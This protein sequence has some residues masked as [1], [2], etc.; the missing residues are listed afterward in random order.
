MSASARVAAVVTGALVTL[1]T[2]V[3]PGT[4]GADQAGFGPTPTPSAPHEVC[5]VAP[6]GHARCFAEIGTPSRGGFGVRG[7]AAHTAAASA[8]PIG[9]GPA[10]LR[11]AYHLTTTGGA[12]QTVALIN[13]GDDATAEADLAVYRQTYGLPPCT[14][15]NGCFRKLNQEGQSAPLPADQGW[16]DEISL[17]LDMVSSAC[18]NCHILLAEGDDS[19]FDNLG[20]ALHAAVAA[21]A[22]VTSNSYGA[23][24]QGAMLPFESLYLRSGVPTVAATGDRGYRPPSFPAVLPTVIAAGGT[25]LTRADNARGWTE[26]AWLGAGS[27]CS[28]W[29]DKPAWQHDPNCSGRTTADVSSVA[30]PDT[31]VAVY[32][33]ADG[34]SGW[35]IGGGTSAASPFIAAVIALGG[36]PERFPDASYLYSHAAG[37]NDVVGGDNALNADCEGDY[38]CDGVVGYDGPTGLGTPD[39]IAAF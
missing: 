5:P 34:A 36:H 21:G 15:A 12:D 24:E 13:A 20:A 3:A 26:S 1:L 14:T 2:V 9:Y 30:D 10:D 22:T 7:K 31:P 19:G 23:D 25:S 37:L 32:D 17:D 11:S 18:P 27:G 29:V 4:A 16:G 8:L 28:A 33:T 35:I 38:L 39:G 6:A